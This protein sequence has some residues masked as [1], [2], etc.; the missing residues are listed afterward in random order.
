MEGLHIV[1]GTPRPVRFLVVM[2]MMT[3]SWMSCA[4]KWWKTQS[5]AMTSDATVHQTMSVTT[6]AT[7][8]QAAVAIL[9]THITAILTNQHRTS[10]KLARPTHQLMCPRGANEYFQ[11]RYQ[12]TF[13]VVKSL[14]TAAERCM[15]CAQYTAADAENQEWASYSTIDNIKHLIYVSFHV[16]NFIRSLGVDF[17]FI[18]SASKWD[19]RLRLAFS[20]SELIAALY[21][22]VG[23]RARP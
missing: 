23:R 20:S 9:T 21:S 19:H 6:R 7:T 1:C 5:I 22:V 18:V 4:E 10:A 3:L 15:R 13:A 11:L 8:P 2:R 12:I 16:Q 14:F 17:T